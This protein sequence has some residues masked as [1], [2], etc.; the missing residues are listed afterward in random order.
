MR[1]VGHNRF[2]PN[3]FPI[4]TRYHTDILLP[5]DCVTDSFTV[6]TVFIETINQH[7]PPSCTPIHLF[8]LLGIWY[9]N[10]IFQ[11][12]IALYRTDLGLFCAVYVQR[13]SLF[14]LH[15]PLLVNTCFGLT[16]HLQTYRLL[17]IRILLLTVMRFSFLLFYLPLVIWLCGLHVVAFGFVWFV[18]CGFLEY[19]FVRWDLSPR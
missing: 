8:Y 6:W 12:H 1:H 7:L 11:H 3:P 5:I 13:R 19:F 9:H 18:G 16:G 15:T 10:V 2:L 14:I 17:W 4:I